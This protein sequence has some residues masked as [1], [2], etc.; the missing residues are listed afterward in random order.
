MQNILW[1]HFFPKIP[2]KLNWKRNFANNLVYLLTVPRI[3]EISWLLQGSQA[4]DETT[5][6]ANYKDCIEPW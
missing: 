2:Y 4:H 5:L 1:S 6:V 3:D